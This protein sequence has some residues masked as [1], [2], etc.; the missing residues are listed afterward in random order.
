MEKQ[1]KML[2]GWRGILRTGKERPVGFGERD[3]K[4]CREGGVRSSI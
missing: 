2:R 1:N 4:G 3:D